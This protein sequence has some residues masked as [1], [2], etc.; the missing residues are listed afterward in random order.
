MGVYGILIWKP[1]GMWIGQVWQ[2]YEIVTGMVTEGYD[3]L[4]NR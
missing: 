1:L 3:W 2:G 4:N